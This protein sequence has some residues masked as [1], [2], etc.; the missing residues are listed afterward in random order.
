VGAAGRAARRRPLT[1]ETSHP[2]G[3]NRSVRALAI[4]LAAVAAGG[5]LTLAGAASRRQAADV[6]VASTPLLGVT[7]DVARFKDLTGQESLVHQAFLGWGQGQ[8]YGAQFAVLL[9]SFGPIPMLHLGTAGRDGKEAI[10]PAGIASGRG[11]GYLIALNEAIAIWG[12]GIYI[13]PMAEMNGIAN[14]YTGYSRDGRPRDAA[15]SP[16]SYRRAFARIY[17]LLHGGPAATINAKLRALGLPGIAHDLPENPFPRLRVVWSPL[18]G[19]NPRVPGN[20]PEMYYPGRAYVDV[21]GGDIYDE[22]LVDTAPWDQLEA[23]FKHSVADGKP[24]SVPEWGLFTIDDPAFVGHMCAFLDTHRTTEVAVFYESRAG[25]IFDLEPKPKSRQRYRECITPQAAPLPSWASAIG[26]SLTA[27]SL[28]PV[29]PSGSAPLAVRF[30]ITATLSVA[31]EHWEVVFGDGAIASGGGPPP[32]SLSHSYS[33]EGVYQA[34]LFVF[35]AP[36]FALADARFFTAATVTVGV[37]AKP[38]VSFVP[39]PTSGRAP[40]KVSFRLELDLPSLVTSWT[41]VYGD[42]LSR[43]Q[44]GAPPHFLGHTY[45]APGTYHVLLL[46]NSGASHTYVATVDITAAG[47]GGG[48]PSST[49]TTTTSTTAAPPATGVAIRTVL[50]NGRPYTGGPIPYGSK[51]DVTKGILVLTTDTGTLRLFGMGGITAIFR[52]VRGTDQG[53][54]I[55]ELQLL[56]GNF[57]VCPKRKKADVLG[58]AAT[59][60]TVRQLWGKGKGRFRTRGRY[61]AATVRGTY[62]LTADRCDGTLVR[63]RAGVVLVSDL[64]KHRQVRVT[65]G[66]TY[67]AKP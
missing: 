41:L 15:H 65:P 51:V 43:E 66:H 3:E 11:D 56:G 20:A 29:P 1:R 45:T 34:V 8:S 57:N 61:A 6:R 28:T 4:M 50:V 10:T 55:V 9:P 53:R 42:G 5:A 46:L 18:A 7:G 12:R 30:Q 59:T 38:R 2:L 62:W 25:S 17:I 40:L 39:T 36:P 35:D 63:V 22:Q 67:L 16:A 23:L 21:E 37:G 13:R 27:L 31:I 26:A 19:G 60:T 47:P 24:F 33:A 48:G 64:P 14:F 54:P 58:S 44:A 52:L 49:T 32:T